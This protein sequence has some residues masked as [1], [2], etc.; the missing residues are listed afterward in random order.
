MTAVGVK[1][2]VGEDGG[3][4]G[5]AIEVYLGDGQFFCVTADRWPDAADDVATFDLDMLKR[6]SALM[7]T[8]GALAAARHSRTRNK[9][10]SAK[11]FRDRHPHETTG[12]DLR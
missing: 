3:D 6:L 5:P 10:R 1:R 12:P 9:S 11:A 2:S 8:R 7:P 4:H